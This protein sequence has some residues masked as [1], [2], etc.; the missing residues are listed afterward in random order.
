MNKMIVSNCKKCGA[1]IT[2]LDLIFDG[3]CVMCGPGVVYKTS[4]P[5][6]GLM[7][8]FIWEERRMTAISEAMARYI[9]AYKAIPQEWIDEYN[10]LA[11]NKAG[12]G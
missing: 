12:R 1:L 7:P 9:A 6:V 8:R 10:E 11:K 2:N 4:V 3:N 5:P